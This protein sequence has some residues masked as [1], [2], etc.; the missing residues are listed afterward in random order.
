[1]VLMVDEDKTR[2]TLLKCILQG[3]HIEVKTVSSGIDLANTLSEEKPDIAILD[4]SI[5]WLNVCEFVSMSRK[6]QKYKDTSFIILPPES[7]QFNNCPIEGVE[8]M[9]YPVRVYEF[10]SIVKKHLKDAS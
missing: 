1:M 8:I 5:K 2:S 4:I 10:L 3:E 7:N 6:M 9:R